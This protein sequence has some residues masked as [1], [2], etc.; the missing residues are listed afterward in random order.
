M[1]WHGGA[2]CESHAIVSDP[3]VYI[4]ITDGT[5][6]NQTITYSL[7]A[8]CELPSSCSCVDSGTAYVLVLMLLYSV[9]T[10]A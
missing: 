5:E 6:T 1:P 9:L 2:D 7:L 3:Q 4:E 10:A 8:A